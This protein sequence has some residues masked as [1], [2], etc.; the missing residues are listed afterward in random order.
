MRSLKITIW[1]IQM[2][3]NYWWSGEHFMSKWFPL[4]LVKRNKFPILG[5]HWRQVVWTHHWW[6]KLHQCGFLGSHRHALT[7]HQGLSNH[8]T[9]FNG[10]RKGVMQWLLYK[11][12]F[13]SR[14]VP[15]MVKW[16]V[17]FYLWMHVIYCLVDL[18]YVIF[19]WFTIGMEINMKSSILVIVSLWLH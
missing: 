9:L 2:L 3:V 17:I 6:R 19:I 8:R 4:N 11:L 13:H 7:T 16:Y 5:V 15:I 10:L 12:L 14:L 18:C 1:S